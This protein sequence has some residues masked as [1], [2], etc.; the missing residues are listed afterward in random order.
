[1]NWAEICEDP[2]LRDL[3][4]KIESDRWG[5][6][7]MSPPPDF[8]HGTYQTEI[9]TLLKRLLPHGL[10]AS[11]CPVE[12]SDGIKGIDVVWLSA[13]RNPGRSRYTVMKVAPEICVEIL[14]AS[15]T[16]AELEERRRLFFERDAVEVWF[17]VEGRMQ[18]FSHAGAIGRSNL[19]PDFPMEIRV[20]AE[21]E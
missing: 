21:P 9:A 16:L 19:C 17:C 6:I 11:E 2:I 14:S 3:P 1:M 12:T 10:V 13:S 7:V 18:F 4:H 20:G 15:N 5:H 8:W